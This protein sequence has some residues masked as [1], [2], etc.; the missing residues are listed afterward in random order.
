MW[1]SPSAGR[2]VGHSSV[3]G[4]PSRQC[5]SSVPSSSRPKSTPLRRC[6]SW[7]KITGTRA[8]RA[9]ATM[10]SA[11][12]IRSSAPGMCGMPDSWPGAADPRWMSTTIS[13]GSPTNKG[14]SG[15]V[16]RYPPISGIDPRIRD[17]LQDVHDGVDGDVDHPEQE[18]DPGYRGEIPRR[19][20]LRHVLADTGPGEDLLHHEHPGEHQ[21][22]LQAG[23]GQGGTEA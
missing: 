18:G 12:D 2:R 3:P 6:A 21:A 19:D 16:S 5:T 11:R 9:A 15:M 1:Y 23:H 10:R 22:H 8:A 17:G 7:K 14:C 20:A 13:A 4:S